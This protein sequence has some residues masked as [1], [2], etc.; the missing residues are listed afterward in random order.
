MRNLLLI[1]SLL[2]S[3]LQSSSQ[4]KNL[5]IELSLFSES[6]AIPFTK[7]LPTPIHPGIQ[8]GTLLRYTNKFT[9]RIFQSINASYFYHNHLNHGISLRTD[10]GYE[11]RSTSGLTADVQLGIGYMHTWATTIEYVFQNGKYEVKNDKGNARLTPSLTFGLGYYL[12]KE[13]VSSPKLFLRYQSWA[14]YPYSPEFIPV[15]TH[16][17]VHAG[18]LIYFKNDEQ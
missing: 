5:P 16:I 11:Y 15:L 4:I 7:V 8:V 17:N 12:Q 13:D 9:H 18:I 10:F 2:F 3:T 6:T 1:A 14:E